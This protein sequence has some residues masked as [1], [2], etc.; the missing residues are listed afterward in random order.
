MSAHMSLSSSMED[1]YKIVTQA[2]VNIKV[3]RK[4]KCSGALRVC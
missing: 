2:N 3:P 1:A 4:G